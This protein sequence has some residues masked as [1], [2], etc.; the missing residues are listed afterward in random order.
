MQEITRVRALCCKCGNLRT[1]STRYAYRVELGYDERSWDDGDD[2]RG[3]R[4]TQ[5]LRCSACKATTIHAVLLD[6]AAPDIRDGAET[7][8]WSTR[9]ELMRI[10]A[11]ITD[12]VGLDDLTTDELRQLVG[13]LVAADA[14]YSGTER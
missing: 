13:I 6:A 1:V 8:Q 4:M 10:S 2:A 5:P 3:W 7:R 11:D 12:R 9:E 14:R